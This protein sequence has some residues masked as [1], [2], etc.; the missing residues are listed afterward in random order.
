[1]LLHTNLFHVVSPELL[2]FF[3]VL[4]LVSQVPVEKFSKIWLG[5]YG[6]FVPVFS[7]HFD[8]VGRQC[9]LLW[10]LFLTHHPVKIS[11][12]LLSNHVGKNWSRSFFVLIFSL[13]H[14]AMLLVIACDLCM[15]ITSSLCYPLV[16]LRSWI[17]RTRAFQWGGKFKLQPETPTPIGRSL[18]QLSLFHF[19]PSFLLM[20]AGRNPL[21]FYMGSYHS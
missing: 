3:Y 7:E 6:L 4:V 5:H 2:L 16:L 18:F 17:V 15:A 12:I 9:H 1:M 19:W 8:T 14:S 13:M 21:W 10:T 20:W 11:H